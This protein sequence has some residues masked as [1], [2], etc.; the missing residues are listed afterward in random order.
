[1]AKRKQISQPAVDSEES[2]SLLSTESNEILDEQQQDQIIQ[3]LEASHALNR[4]LI[5]GF[6]VFFGVS[7]ITMLGYSIFKCPIVLVY[8]YIA[9]FS[10]L[11]TTWRLV[12]DNSCCLPASVAFALAPFGYVILGQNKWAFPNPLEYTFIYM[13]ILFNLF[14]VILLKDLMGELG[15][16][17]QLKLKRYHHKSA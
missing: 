13:P 7:F 12:K 17:E 6:F 4:K 5:R 14:A 15:E 3:E 16:I 1:M 11:E 8:N 10:F 2:D 9:M